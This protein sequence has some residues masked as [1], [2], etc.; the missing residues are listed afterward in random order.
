MM[1]SARTAVTSLSM[2][3][4]PATTASTRSTVSAEAIETCSASAAARKNHPAFRAFPD[5][6]ALPAV[7]A[8]P[9]FPAILNR[10]SKGLAERD[11]ERCGAFAGLR[12]HLESE[13]EPQRSDGRF[14]QGSESHRRAKLAE[15]N[16][17]RVLKH[18]T[19]VEKR[20]RLDVAPGRDPY[21]RVEQHYC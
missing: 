1:P 4:C 8:L 15:V 16:A 20:V 10:T 6:P 9:A 3:S 11:E 13:V 17:R 18:I 7:S 14:V 12:A 5:L 21:L 2:I 19:R